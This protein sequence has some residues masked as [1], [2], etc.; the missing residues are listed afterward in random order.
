MTTGRRL[1]SLWQRLLLSYAL[2]VLV[3]VIVF[4]L[5]AAWL[6][7]KARHAPIGVTTPAGF[8]SYMHDLGQSLLDALFIAA[9][10][11]LVVGAIAT[12]A[13][14]KLI[15]E[16]LSR[17][18]AS[19]RRMREG[20]Y[21]E[22]IALPYQPEL[23][24]LA[25]DLNLLAA[26]LADVE[27]RRA[28]LVSDLAHE[29]RTPLTII[30]GQL[31]GVADG[32]YEFSD[33]LV[34]SVREELDRLRRL[35]ED[36]SGLS[37][38]EENAYTLTRQDT[39]LSSLARRVSDRLRPQFSA[40][41]I[42]L[43]TTTS[44]P[45]CASIDPERVNQ[46]VANLLLNALAATPGGGRVALAVSPEHDDSVMIEVTDNGR[47]IAATDIE[48]IFERFERVAP[49][50]EAPRGA[51]SGIGLTIARSLAR[52]HGGDLS[53]ASSG[54]GTGATFTLRLPRQANAAPP[55]SAHR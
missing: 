5:V 4:A 11:S 55:E 20:N 46:I 15:L 7:Q 36:L 44:G 34:H 27:T 49:I 54:P 24:E 42:A 51:G 17:L 52:A 43:T 30:E 2:V 18:S 3:D 39:D 16:P 22:Q 40:R 31:V 13:I 26:R 21:G 10:I 14:T 38:A 29:L 50:H 1:R 6:S 19:A 48:R 9:A 23:T 45:A 12:V 28:R 25:T 53:A 41:D 33:E 35:T 8:E 32:V 37:R 47:G